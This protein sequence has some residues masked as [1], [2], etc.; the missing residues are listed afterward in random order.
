MSPQVSL[1]AMVDFVVWSLKMMFVVLYSV[2]CGSHAWRICFCVR[3]HLSKTCIV[4][5]HIISDYRRTVP[6]HFH[7]D[8]G[9]HVTFGF[10]VQ[11]V[12][13]G[14]KLQIF[15]WRSNARGQLAQTPAVPS[16]SIFAR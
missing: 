7:S 5:A 2:F 8:D 9:F 13:K 15:R 6:A 3:H 10:V 11:Q 16:D 1:V 4:H 14:T 12:L